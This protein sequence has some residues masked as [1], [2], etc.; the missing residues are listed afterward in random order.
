MNQRK[1]IIRIQISPKL[2][3]RIN[4][5]TIKILI[6][7]L[8]MKIDKLILKLVKKARNPEQ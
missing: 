4:K 8:F 2:F 6:L 3:C 7:L 1:N 5:V